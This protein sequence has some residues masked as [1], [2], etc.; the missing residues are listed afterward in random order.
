MKL[1][2]DP[3]EIGNIRLSELYFPVF[4]TTSMVVVG[5]PNT[6]KY[7]QDERIVGDRRG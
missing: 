5:L 6:G 2:R 4:P 1:I 3:F 7:G